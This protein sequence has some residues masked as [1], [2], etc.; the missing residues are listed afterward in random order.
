M[1]PQ[2]APSRAPAPAEALSGVRTLAELNAIMS[3]AD[4]SVRGGTRAVLGEGPLHPVLAFVGEQ[5]G[6]QEDLQGRPFVG[7]AGELLT[8]AMG[9]AGI[10]RAASYVTNAVKH[11]K[12]EQRGKRRLHQKPT[13]GEVSHYRWWLKRELEIVA[14]KLVVALGAT[15]VLALAGKALPVTKFRGAFRFDGAPG[16]ITVHPSYLLRIPDAAAKRAAYDAFVADLK[17]A[18]VLANR[19]PVRRAGRNGGR[20]A[21]PRRNAQRT[22]ARGGGHGT[23]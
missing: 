5:P 16:Y 2:A 1:K 20:G 4:P 12:F 23:P 19:G 18:R 15:A 14:P 6:D 21:P 11:F 7:P 9:D 13:A 8:R 17:A 22:G 3:A 10:R